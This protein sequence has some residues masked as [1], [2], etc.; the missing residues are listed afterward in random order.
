M[1]FSFENEDT[2][3]KAWPVFV[4]V[5]AHGRHWLRENGEWL[6]RGNVSVTV[7]S[8]ENFFHSRDNR[9]KAELNPN[10]IFVVYVRV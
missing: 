4:N 3:T 8:S 7:F 1:N 10:Q 6:L 5:R 9:F 2:V